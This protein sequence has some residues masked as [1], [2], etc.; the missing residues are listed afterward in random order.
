MSK[1]WQLLTLLLVFSSWRVLQVFEVCHLT[2]KPW[3]VAW[4]H[5]A[6][7]GLLYA[8]PGTCPILKHRTPARSHPTPSSPCPSAPCTP[9]RTCKIIPESCWVRRKVLYIQLCA[10]VSYCCYFCPWLGF[11]KPLLAEVI[12]SHTLNVFHLTLGVSPPMD[13][14]V[15][16]RS[17]HDIPC[18][19]LE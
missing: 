11:P 18:P 10:N 1:C 12:L 7:T 17:E 9:Q 4:N 13:K 8:P 5:N 6:H 14:D 16:L 15:C 3:Y 19:F 2:P